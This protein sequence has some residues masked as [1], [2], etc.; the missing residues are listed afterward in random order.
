[1]AFSVLETEKD[2][3]TKPVANLHESAKNVKV[4]V[5][6]PCYRGKDTVERCVNSIIQQKFQDLELIVID[7][8]GGDSIRV[9]S[10]TLNKSS[11]AYKI[12][13]H[14]TNK[15]IANTLNEGLKLALGD[16]ILI[17]HQ[18]C[19][20]LD[21]FHIED[22]V[23]FLDLNPDVA[24]L[25]GSPQYPVDEFN[26]FEKVFMIESG[27]FTKKDRAGIEEVSFS[28]HKCDIFRKEVLMKSGGFDS[29]HFRASAED[30]MVSWK[31]RNLGYKIV[32]SNNLR[33][34]QRYGKS[35]STFAGLIKKTFY[36]SKTQS[37]VILLTQGKVLKGS[38]LKTNDQKMRIINRL[39]GTI[40]AMLFLFS[41][42]PLII[43]SEP[44]LALVSSGIVFIRAM[45]LA[46]KAK[47]FGI[48]A[49]WLILFG[50][51]L[52]GFLGDL[53]YLTGLSYGTLLTFMKK[54]L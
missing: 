47:A 21:N 12:V 18:D 32:K 20:L 8:N 13:I 25:G 16:Y 4:T 15:G 11:I 9:V 45:H 46:Q 2:N 44:L 3:L 48:K 37:G 36:Y 35:V 49:N 53:A 40:F 31:I 27:H 30:Q 33:Y 22:A 51:G 50:M 1:M 39:T 7:D 43:F 41:L 23:K 28:E 29:K 26:F 52:V 38:S 24:V 19:E 17:V 34:L 42:V 54:R 5:I 14:E 6:L 10:R